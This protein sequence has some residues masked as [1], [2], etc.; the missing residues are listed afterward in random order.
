ML[1]VH[2]RF[3]DQDAVAWAYR[4]RNLER[5][6][7]D[8]FYNPPR[9]FTVDLAPSIAGNGFTDPSLVQGHVG[10]WESAS[11]FKVIKIKRTAN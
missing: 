6:L 11:I 1:F 9:P 3:P 4:V 5:V 10:D 8:D 2:S 7:V